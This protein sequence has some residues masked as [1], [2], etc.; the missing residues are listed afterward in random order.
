MTLEFLYTSQSPESNVRRSDHNRRQRTG[1]SEEE[2]L[3]RARISIFRAATVVRFARAGSLVRRRQALELLLQKG[4]RAGGH[5]QVR[6]EL[7]HVP[8]HVRPERGPAS[9]Q[10]EGTQCTFDD[11]L[12]PANSE[13]VKKDGFDVVSYV[14]ATDFAVDRMRSLPLCIRLL[15]E[16]H[17]VLLD[18]T[19][20][21]KKNPGQTQSSQNW[22]ELRA[23]RSR[24]PLTRRL[25]SKTWRTP[26]PIW[27][28]SYIRCN[29]IVP[30][31]RRGFGTYSSAPP[32]IA[33]ALEHPRLA[34]ALQ[35]QHAA[36]F[37]FGLLA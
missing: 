16:A 25:T 14:R 34:F 37:A 18:G 23:V 36:V 8:G 7:Q 19:R 27:R 30:D 33:F 17:G 24:M 11:V 13:P 29:C 3:G 21:Q 1:L 5:A 2:P 22:I 9:A 32:G 20:G 6:P 4:R 26:Y 10:I 12:D 15:K 31:G 28:D 35:L